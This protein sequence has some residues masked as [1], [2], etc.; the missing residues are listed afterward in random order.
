[1]QHISYKS[2]KINF[3]AYLKP[4]D[5]SK[6][7]DLELLIWPVSLRAHQTSKTPHS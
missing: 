4:W 6:I 7:V 1:M 2:L 5:H 3:L